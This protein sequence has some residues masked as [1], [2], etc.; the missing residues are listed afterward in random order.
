MALRWQCLFR[1]FSSPLADGYRFGAIGYRHLPGRQCQ[2]DI[3]SG[4]T[5]NDL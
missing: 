2:P 4:L 1:S 5:A 3:V